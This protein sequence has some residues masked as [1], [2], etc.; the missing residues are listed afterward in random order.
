MTVSTS[1]RLSDLYVGNNVNTNFSFTFRVFKQEGEDGISV[2]LKT[3]NGFTTLDKALYNVVLNTDNLGGQVVFKAPPSQID[4]FYIAGTTPADQ[5]LDITN[6]DNFYPDAIE[7]AL[8]KLTAI[9]QEWST[10]LTQ[11]TQARQIKDDLLEQYIKDYVDSVLQINN[12]EAITS[13][14]ADIVKTNVGGNPYNQQEFNEFLLEFV[15][16]RYPDINQF[17]EQAQEAFDSFVLTNQ[18]LINETV[19]QAQQDV[20]IAIAGI[21]PTVDAAVANAGNMIG[22]A[23]KAALD[24]ITDKPINQNAMLDNGDIYRWNG[25]IWISTGLNYFNYVNANP[26]FKPVTLTN[27]NNLNDVRT[28]GLHKPNT[29]VPSLALNYPVTGVGELQVRN[30]GGNVCVQTYWVYGTF[31]QWIRTTDG[32]GNWLA[33]EQIGTKSLID[34]LINAAKAPVNLTG[35]SNIDLN[36]LT[37]QGVSVVY[38]TADVSVSHFP[39]S[40]VQAFVLNYTLTTHQQQIFLVRGTNEMYIRT[41]WGSN[42]WTAW[43]LIATTDYVNTAITD[44]LNALNLAKYENL[45][46]S[47]SLDKLLRDPLRSSRIKMIADSIGWGLGASNNSDPNPP[48][49]P[50][51]GYLTDA[52][53]TTDPISPTFANLLRRWIA[54]VYGNKTITEDRPGS[55]YTS[56]QLVT[57]WREI[58]KS[59][60]MTTNQAV[61]LTDTQKL[62][63]IDVQNSF[64]VSGTSVNLLSTTFATA[65]RPQQMEFDITGDNITVLYQKQNIG[66]EN[67]IVDIYVDNVKVDSFNYFNATSDYTAEKSISFTYG[68]HTIKLVNTATHASSYVRLGGFKVNKK[69]W[70]INEGIIGLSTATLLSRNILQDTINQYDDVVL[71]QLGTND[72]QEIG[73]V[74]GYKKRLNDSL[75]LILTLNPNAKIILM[76]SSYAQLD[77]PSAPYKF[78]M[79]VVDRVIASVARERNFIF[80]S[81]YKGTAEKMIEGANLWSDGLHFNDAGNKAFFDTMVDKLFTYD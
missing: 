9:L 17:I 23:N 75:D 44:A 26:L 68:K 6:Y 69:I 18:N 31:G 40:G 15:N 81:N 30:L 36:T 28:E 54:W 3:E 74:E 25:A 41:Y 63:V 49:N 13:I 1:T 38:S 7:I 21:Q 71:F 35:S 45:I 47:D 80:I 48:D 51:T 57:H 43:S 70:L 32:S 53:N 52:R 29:G 37:I 12:P 55:A 11:E 5:Q 33:W 58:Y 20:S 79:G 65:F 42:G 76:S 4:F 24:L 8:D 10:L 72:R 56:K 64:A 62:A 78:D 34:S 46:Y 39:K 22:A 59:V 19:A 27:A 16:T 61:V 60:K 50:R 14:L 73:G 77:A 66:D 2:R 67:N